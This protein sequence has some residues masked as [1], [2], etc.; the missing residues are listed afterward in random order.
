MISFSKFTVVAIIGFGVDVFIVSLT[1]FVMTS[2]PDEFCLSIG[3]FGAVLFNYIC[4]NRWTFKHA[5]KALS[6]SDALRY[7]FICLVILL[8]RLGILYLNNSLMFI[9]EPL[10]LFPIIYFASFI[11]GF[12]VSKMYV[13]R[14]SN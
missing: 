10:A 6:F 8:V 3:F 4:H 5:N 9:L 2:M 1:K 13:F 7:L 14:N 12:L 11:V